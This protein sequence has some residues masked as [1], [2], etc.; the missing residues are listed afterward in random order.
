MLKR[1]LGVLG[2]F[3]PTIFTTRFDAESLPGRAKCCRMDFD[4][5]AGSTGLRDAWNYGYCSLFSHGQCLFVDNYFILRS[6]NDFLQMVC[7]WFHCSLANYF[8]PY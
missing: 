4:H 7:S 5:A 1:M 8:L 3:D 6:R 2:R